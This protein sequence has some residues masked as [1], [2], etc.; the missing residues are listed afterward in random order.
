MYALS[1]GADGARDESA[2][3]A[4]S[5]KDVDVI[6]NAELVLQFGKDTET[7]HGH[8]KASRTQ[9]IQSNPFSARPVDASRP[10]DG[11]LPLGWRP[12]EGSSTQAGEGQA[13]VEGGRL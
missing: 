4:L 5:H 13:P 2:C 10:V 8:P 11:A 3:R 1:S 12:L 6:Q 9:H 7:H